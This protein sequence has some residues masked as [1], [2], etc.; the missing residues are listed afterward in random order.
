M[1]LSENRV[2]NKINGFSSFSSFSPW[3][4][5]FLGESRITMDNFH[6]KTSP[7]V[8]PKPI[9]YGSNPHHPR[10]LTD[11]N[12]HCA[13][14]TTWR[15]H[16]LVDLPKSEGQVCDLSPHWTRLTGEKGECFLKMGMLIMWTQG[17]KPS[18]K[19]SPNDRFMAHWVV[20]QVLIYVDL[21][22]DGKHEDQP[23]KFGIPF[24][25]KPK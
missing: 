17:H 14:V 25:N 22:F 10:H 6:F 15:D 16:G 9:L 4:I 2:P 20:D 11:R 12:S 7:H 13:M 23:S 3:K 5:L 8:E 24:S 21:F 19:S 18:L 1:E